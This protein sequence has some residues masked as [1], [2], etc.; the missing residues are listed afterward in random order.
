MVNVSAALIFRGGRFLI[1][2]RPAQ[3]A[4]G[5]L[6][7][8]VGG[9]REAG[10]TGEEALRREC[11]E[12]LGVAVEPDG[13]FME[14]THVYPDITVRLTVYTA[15]ILE[16]EPQLLEH[17]ALAWITPAE[18]G[19]YDFCP[20]DEAILDRIRASSVAEHPKVKDMRR[21]N[22][23]RATKV[24][25]VSAPITVN[26]RTGREAA[27]F[28][29]EVTSPLYVTNAHGARVKIADRGWCWYQLA[30]P[31][32][33]VWLTAMTDEADRLSQI[34]FDV[35]A[36]ND[37]S[38][39]ENPRFTD[40][41]LDLVLEEDFTL[42][43][44]DREELDEAFALG[45]VDERQYKEILAVGEDARQ[46]LE[47]NKRRLAAFVLGRVKALKNSDG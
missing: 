40:L 47:A 42:R 27:H 6:W 5:L 11:M 28:L 17:N 30:F 16:G 8:F 9:K 35:T 23:R 43:V 29:E 25:Y 2:Q 14:V 3:K 39:P 33:R 20:A 34:Y 19:Q 15:R 24:R 4:R 18:I 44:L 21:E 45:A 31:D 36:G 7:E 46:K 37:F 26:A 22:W 12:E 13:V 32:E 41:W 38:D 1:C 10:E